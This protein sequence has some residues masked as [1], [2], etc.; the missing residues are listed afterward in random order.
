MLARQNGGKKANKTTLSHTRNISKFTP[1][2]FT[3]PSVVSLEKSPDELALVAFI[4][5]FSLFLLFLLFTLTNIYIYIYI[6]VCV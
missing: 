2:S 3:C 6:C 5:T 4:I 1:L